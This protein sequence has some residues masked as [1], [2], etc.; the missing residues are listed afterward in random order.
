[1]ISE[2]G[3]VLPG[4]LQSPIHLFCAQSTPD[5]AQTTQTSRSPKERLKCFLRP[6]EKVLAKAIGHEFPLILSKAKLFMRAHSLQGVILTVITV[7]NLSSLVVALPSRVLRVAAFQPPAVSS[8]FH[9]RMLLGL[10]SVF[11]GRKGASSMTS[12]GLIFSVCRGKL[13]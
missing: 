1:M 8:A 10:L 9:V 4:V 11:S 5:L 7:A 6:W 13:I 12:R 3:Q 2:L